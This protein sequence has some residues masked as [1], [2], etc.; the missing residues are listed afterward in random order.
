[1]SDRINIDATERAR[2]ASKSILIACEESAT[3]RDAFIEAGYTGAWSCDLL[4]TRGKTLGQHGL[5]PPGHRLYDFQQHHQ[6]D[7]LALIYGVGDSAA[8]VAARSMALEAQSPVWDLIVAHPTC[9]YLTNSGVRWLYKGG[10]GNVRDEER[11]A[12]MVN[13]A[14]FFNEL[15]FARR[16]GRCKRIGVENPIPHGYAAELIGEPTQIVQPWMFGHRETKATCF[17]LEELPP[18]TPTNVVGPPR[19]AAERKEFAVVHHMRPGPM[20]ERD[21]SKTYPGIGA[22]I[23][24]Q[25]GPL[26]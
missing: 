8:A 1:M 19:T 26:L 10:R 20:R 25:W 5:Y 15:L 3:V 13:G 4:P 7:V 24:K 9:R 11:W 2:R 12:H 22:A 21:R 18:L 17:W 16:R 23:V 6:C 14:T